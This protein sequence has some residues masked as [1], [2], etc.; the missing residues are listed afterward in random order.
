MTIPEISKSAL[1]YLDLAVQELMKEQ[2]FVPESKDEAAQWLEQNSAAIAQRA[3]NLQQDCY[4][5]FLRNQKPISSIF[6]L[7]IWLY[8]Q[9]RKLDEMERKSIEG[10]L[11]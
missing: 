9:R 11:K 8:F 10:I 7:K 3:S 6:A 1:A 4:E 5:K 2:G